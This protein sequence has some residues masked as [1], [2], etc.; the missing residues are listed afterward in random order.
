MY[1][2]VRALLSHEVPTGEMAAVFKAALELAAAAL[3]KRKFAAT[4]RPGTSRGSADPRHIPAAVKRAVWERDGGQCTFVSDGGNR[5]AARTRLEFDHRE[6]VA[7][8]GG[9]TTENIRLLCRAHNQHTAE[10][11]FGVEF[12]VQ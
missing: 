5:C 10:R 8:G 2:H 9:S 11:E 3:E 6:A 4:D 7:C 12:M 1:E